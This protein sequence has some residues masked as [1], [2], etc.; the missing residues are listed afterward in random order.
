MSSLFEV[1]AQLALVLTLAASG[2]GD[3]IRAAPP[4]VETAAI[5]PTQVLLVYALH[6]KS[7][8]GEIHEVAF[9]S[10]QTSSLSIGYL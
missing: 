3:G 2:P 8:R 7:N 10:K 4:P 6:L 9:A 5:A 1:P